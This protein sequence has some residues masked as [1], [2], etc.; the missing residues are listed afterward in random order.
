MKKLFLFL[1]TAFIA[2]T[3]NAASPLKIVFG[4]TSFL[5]TGTNAYVEMDFSNATWEKEETLKQ[6]FQNEY[7]ELINTSQSTFINAFNSSSNQLKFVGKEEKPQ[8]KIVIKFDNL[9]ATVGG[10]YRKYVRVW[11]TAT[12]IDLS[13]NEEVCIIKITKLDGDG[14]YVTKEAT[15]KSFKKLG[16]LLAKLKQ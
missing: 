4:T 7:D 14:D 12:I 1:I 16:E 6:H 15:W 8:Y 13:S 9:H 5:R 2:V 10:F 11:G 3:V